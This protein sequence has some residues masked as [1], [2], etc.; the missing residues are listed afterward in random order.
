MLTFVIQNLRKIGIIIT[1]LTINFYLISLPY[2]L[3]AKQLLFK[4][5]MIK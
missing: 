4:G 5:K 3:C 1:P 2:L